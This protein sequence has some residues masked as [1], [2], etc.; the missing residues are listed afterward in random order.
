MPPYPIFI[1]MYE[2]ANSTW[3][4]WKVRKWRATTSM[5]KNEK[6]MIQK[7]LWKGTTQI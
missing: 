2:L 6:S 7:E 4:E 1:N 5:N 3:E